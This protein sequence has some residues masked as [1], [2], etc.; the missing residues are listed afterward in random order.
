MDILQNAANIGLKV[1]LQYDCLLQVKA[2]CSSTLQC[3]WY[4]PTERL[5]LKQ[6]CAC[7][8][9]TLQIHNLKKSRTV[10][11]VHIHYCAQPLAELS[12]LKTRPDLWQKVCRAPFSCKVCF[13]SRILAAIKKLLV[14][15]ACLECMPSM[16]VAAC[17]TLLHSS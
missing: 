10:R 3:W 2:L 9:F 14:V 13:S 8:S 5:L 15:Q 4:R 16:I 7:R 1:P 17:V 12:E 11:Q 6:W